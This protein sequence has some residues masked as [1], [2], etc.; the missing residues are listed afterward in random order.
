MFSTWFF[1]TQDESA[2]TGKKEENS[3][4]NWL[5]NLNVNFA[6]GTPCCVP[7]GVVGVGLDHFNADKS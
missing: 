7:I 2:D 5:Q 1:P 4:A 6:V 3:A